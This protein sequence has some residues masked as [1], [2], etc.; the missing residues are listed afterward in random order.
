MINQSLINL[1]RLASFIHPR[2]GEGVQDDLS[3]LSGV[4]E[5]AAVFR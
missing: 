2:E 1:Q 3:A 4:G 5:E